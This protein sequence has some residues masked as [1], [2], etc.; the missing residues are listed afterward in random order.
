MKFFLFLLQCLVLIPL[1][2][3]Q[4]AGF[5]WAAAFGGNDPEY[6]SDILIDD[7]GNSYTVGVFQEVVDF[8]PG[9]GIFELD[10][11]DSFT[12]FILKLNSMGEFEWVK[13]FD[14][15][16]DGSGTS[17][18][19]DLEGNILCS[20]IFISTVD[21]DPGPDEYNIT[22]AGNR[23]Y[24]ILKLDPSGNF[25]SVITIGGISSET[26]T[27]T[28][29]DAAGNMYT[30]GLFTG[31]TDFDPGLDEYVLATSGEEDVYIQKLDAEGNF[32]WARS[33]GGSLDDVPRGIQLDAEGNVF[34]CGRFNGT[35]DFN[36]GPDSFFMSS[37]GSDDGFILKLNTDGEFVWSAK[38]GGVTGD[39]A[40]ACEIDSEGNVYT[41]GQY[42]S[43]IDFDPGIGEVIVPAASLIDGYILKLDND[44]DFISVNTIS[45]AES[46]AYY[47]IF[48]D[49]SNELFLTGVYLG[50]TDFDPSGGVYNQTS[51][52]SGD[53]FV[54]HLDSDGNLIWVKTIGGEGFD[55]GSE[56]KVS[57]AGDIYISGTF[58]ETVDFNPNFEIEERTSNGS[59]DLF[60]MKLSQCSPDAT[61]DVLNACNSFTWINGITY[62]EDNNS[63]TWLL[64]NVGGCDSLVTLDLTIVELDNSVSATAGI[65]SS[66][67]LDAGY[68]WLDCNDGYAEIIGEISQDYVP[69]ID[70]D[71]AVRIEQGSCVDTSECIT[72]DGVGLNE[73]LY[74]KSI[75]LYP[76]PNK[77]HFIIQGLESIEYR[78]IVYSITGKQIKKQSIVGVDQFEVILPK[79]QYVLEL[80]SDHSLN[81]FSVV[82]LE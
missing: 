46:E 22:S 51:N 33:I 47:N 32:I 41:V 39:I 16:S 62:T 1:I 30:T 11:G 35:A 44:G 75:I 43:E 40:H 5:Q 72:I 28:V 59:S 6:T 57:I 79:G 71:Y 69:T 54:Q 81:H 50:I 15:D 67:D 24:F 42:G 9:P 76:N 20:G 29:L 27:R 14:S 82:V 37:E 25:I 26:A 63:A 58:E 10:G 60:T 80:I 65:I 23:D 36:P 53:I 78:L 18:S 66:A 74:G 8:D 38:I 64:S 73:T 12:P 55:E 3:A 31:A 56:I 4:D 17:L 77:G 19:F 61:T 13:T 21:F 68:Q 34:V 48:I 7:E 52:G 45:S 49:A 2:N 70:G